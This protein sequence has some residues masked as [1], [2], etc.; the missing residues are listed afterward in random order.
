MKAQF[1]RATLIGF[2]TVALLAPAG[3]AMLPV[4]GQ[5]VGTADGFVVNAQVVRHG[6][7]VR[8]PRGG[9]A[10]R[11]G[12]VVRGAGGAVAVRRGAVVGGW[13]RPR[14]RWAPGGA[15]AA[16]AA[17]GVLA[18]GAAIAIAGQPPAPGL[19]WYYT[20]PSQTQGFWD[21]C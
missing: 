7:V 10:V 3:A 12:T 16:G 18:A 2:A 8:G 21:R 20:D 4:M 14:Y 15:I 1:F 9:V 5:A 11:R 6:T 17:I 13:A 19:C